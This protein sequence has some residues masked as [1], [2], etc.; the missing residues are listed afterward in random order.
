MIDAA[1]RL[2]AEGGVAAMSLRAVQEAAGQRNKSAAHYHFGSRDGLLA[3]IVST[4]SAPIDERRAVLLDELGDDPSL[5]DLVRAFVQPFAEA[6]ASGQSYWARFLRVAI[7]D[8]AT[9]DVITSSLSEATYRDVRTR[10]EG[11]IDHLDDALRGRRLNQMM[12]LVVW[13]LAVAEAAGDD[14]D[15][16]DLVVV[17]TAVLTAPAA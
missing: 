16:D 10:L 1:E 17:A 3:A 8:P 4:R 14:V 12:A 13:T 6:S 2:A 7:A 11:A 15:V 9:N 5:A